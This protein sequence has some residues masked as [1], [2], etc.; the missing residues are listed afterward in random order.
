[1][2]DSEYVYFLFIYRLKPNSHQ[3]IKLTDGPRR[4]PTAPDGPR[5]PPTA[6]DL[7][8]DEKNRLV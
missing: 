1:M 8:I 7:K 2:L 6:P 3:T 4:P 5:R